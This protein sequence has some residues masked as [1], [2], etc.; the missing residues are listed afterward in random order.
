MTDRPGLDFS[1]SG[2]KTFTLNTLARGHRDERLLADVARAF[3][4]AVVDTLVDQMP[5][6][7]AGDRTAGARRLRRRQREPAASRGAHGD[8][9]PRR[10]GGELSAS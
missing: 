10:S 1:F 3:E 4:D 9:A 5:P 7:P 6:R 8:G 2:L